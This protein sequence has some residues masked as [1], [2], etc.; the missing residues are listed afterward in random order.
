MWNWQKIG[1]AP[2]FYG[3]MRGVLVNVLFAG[4]TNLQSSGSTS[5]A[6]L[7]GMDAQTS[8]TCPEGTTC[9]T[10]Q[11]PYRSALRSGMSSVVTMGCAIKQL[12]TKPVFCPDDR[13]GSTRRYCAPRFSVENEETWARASDVSHAFTEYETYWPH[14]YVSMSGYYVEPRNYLAQRSRMTARA[15]HNHVCEGVGRIN[16]DLW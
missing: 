4:Q 14:S 9:N 5:G 16:C 6:L 2:D 13:V 10:R 7:P 3:W 15:R 8:V 11:E 1:H 12:R